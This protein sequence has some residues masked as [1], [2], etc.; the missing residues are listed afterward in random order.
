[1][2]YFRNINV[3]FILY[4][5]GFRRPL[6]REQHCTVAADERMIHDN[7]VMTGQVGGGSLPFAWR[8]VGNHEK[9]K[10]GQPAP[11]I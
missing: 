6:V 3:S 10:S 8:D 9:A 2:Y 4:G 1:M 5:C 11:G 7:Y